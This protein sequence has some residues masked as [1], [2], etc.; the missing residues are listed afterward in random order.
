MRRSWLMLPMALLLL[1]GCDE[2]FLVI[3]SDT[4]WEGEIR[5]LGEVG[6]NGNAEIDLSDEPADVCWTLRKTTAEGTLRAYLRDETW[7]GLGE[8][9]DGDQTTTAAEGEVTGC[10]E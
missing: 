1:A 6:G 9:V 2:R 8:E 10:N 4:S 7:F 3:E 5:Y